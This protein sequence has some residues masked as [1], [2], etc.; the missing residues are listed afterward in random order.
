LRK[1]CH[2]KMDRLFGRNSV[3]TVEALFNFS[4]LEKP[5]QRHLKNVYSTLSIGLLAAA[6]G[7]YIHIFTNLAQAGFL[8]LVVSIGC[9]MALMFTE[10]KSENVPKRMAYF[11]GFALCTGMGL[12]PLLDA[13]I[14]ID[15]S[16]VVTAFLGAAVIFV[17]FSVSSLVS[18][19]S[20]TWLYM[21]G[22]LM[23]GVSLLLVLSLANMFMRS[24]LLL[25]VELYLGFGIFCLFVLYDTQLI[26]QKRRMGDEDFV[27]HAVD[28]FID[29]IELFRTLLTILGRKEEDKERKGRKH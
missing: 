13:V 26:V 21:G 25:T 3:N 29:F 28:L 8:S 22:S 12:G 20:R 16:I 4:H 23:S 18:A 11:T 1:N 17:C 9:L 19:N 5:V 6:A 15:P 2:T 27:W 10:H 24:E 14:R 7:A